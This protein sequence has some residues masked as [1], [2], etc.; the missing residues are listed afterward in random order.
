MWLFLYQL[1]FLPNNWFCRSANNNAPATDVTTTK[2]DF[3][4]YSCLNILLINSDEVSILYA[5]MF[6][7]RG[8]HLKKAINEGS[9]SFLLINLR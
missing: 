1:K 3:Y 7:L 4:L 9:F 5:L 2:Y 8:F 6:L